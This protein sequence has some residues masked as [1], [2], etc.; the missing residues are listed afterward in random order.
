MSEPLRVLLLDEAESRLA[1]REMLAG[2]EGIE[3]VDSPPGTFS[4][5]AIGEMAHRIDCVLAGHHPSTIDAGAVLREVRDG[6]LGLPVIV[7]TADGDPRPAVELLKAGASEYLIKGAVSGEALA[8]SVRSTVRVHR[9]E[10]AAAAARA[11]VLAANRARDE[12]VALLDTLVGGAPVGIAFFD[13]E[14]R[15]VR[16][17]RELARINGVSVEAHL[18]KTVA[19][20]LPHMNPQVMIDLGEVLRSGVPVVNIDVTGE[21]PADPGAAHDWIVSYYPVRSAGGETLGVGATVIDITDR[22]R[23]QRELAQA[24]EAA[25][26]ANRSKDQF[27]AVLSHE[28]RTPLTPVLMAV[29]AMQEDGVPEEL[30]GMLAMIR[31]NVELEARLI[32]DLLDLTRIAKGKLQ[33]H[34]EMIDAHDLITSALEICRGEI[35]HKGLVVNVELTA[36]R[37]VVYADSARLQQVFWNLIN[38]A[39]KFTP[40]G[41]ALTIRSHDEEERLVAE[42]SDSGIGIDADTLPRIFDAFEQGE[43]TI[44]RRFGGLGLGLAIC[45]ALMRMH[46]GQIHASSA[47]KGKGATFTIKLAGHAPA[48]V[49]RGAPVVTAAKTAQP[50]VKAGAVPASAAAA[51]APDRTPCRVLMVDDHE[52]T[53]AAMKKLLERSGY[54][55]TTADSVQ[56][57]IAGAAGELPIDILISDIGLPDGSGLEIMRHFRHRGGGGQPVRGIALSGFG[58]EED[59]RRSRE[60]GFEH[61]LT[62]PVTFDRLRAALKQIEAAEK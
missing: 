6:G 22:K 37:H 58:M 15:Y 10:M 12:A 51:A 34:L 17:N 11:N 60:A 52:D 4:L 47:G 14:L 2:A 42:V 28:L 57:A 20:L 41:G 1:V 5:K 56:G 36:R 45:R 9:A 53:R 43:G 30:R 23:H 59:I 25:E 19:E 55:V 50:R 7:F 33:L 13:T 18:G 26:A 49:V 35:E 16:V 21:T 44:T 3:L 40:A 61:H 24:K 32:D 31:R 46:W 27:L 39:V 48:T 54:H 38:N 29:Q 8:R 62:K